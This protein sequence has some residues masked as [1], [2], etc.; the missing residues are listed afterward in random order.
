MM[1]GFT[2]TSKDGK[3]EISY[4][5]TPLDGVLSVTIKP[6]LPGEAVVASVEIFNPTLSLYDVRLPP[7]DGGC[8]LN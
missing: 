4:D 2:I 8:D 1:K 5:G 6:I 7:K 3:H